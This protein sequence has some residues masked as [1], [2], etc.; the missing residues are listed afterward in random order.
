MRQPVA[1][2][3][4]SRTPNG[5]RINGFVLID[6]KNDEYIGPLV[7][8]DFIN[9]L[10]KN[11]RADVAVLVHSVVFG[12]DTNANFRSKNVAPYAFADDKSGDYLSYTF[13][14]GQHTMTAALTRRDDGEF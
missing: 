14:S 8:A 2:T 10:A 3:Q 13:A 4:P 12:F 6:A 1:P 9:G 5:P 11:I 7:A